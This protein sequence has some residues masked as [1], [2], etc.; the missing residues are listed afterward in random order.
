VN[1]IYCLEEWRGEQRISP[2]GDNFTHRDKIHHWGTTSSL[3]VKFAPRGEVKNEPQA[4]IPPIRSPCIVL[5]FLL[6]V[7][8]T[9]PICIMVSLYTNQISTYYKCR[10]LQFTNKLFYKI[11]PR[12]WSNLSLLRLP[13]IDFFG[14][15][16]LKFHI[17]GKINIK[18]IWIKTQFDKL[19]NLLKFLIYNWNVFSSSPLHWI[20]WN[21]LVI[22]WSR[23]SWASYISVGV[24]PSVKAWQNC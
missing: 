24:N 22:F 15:V 1:T 10:A 16:W 14:T 8:E 5:T 6:W 18:L 21:I 7:I 17:L 3:G 19:R 2:P 13:R 23:W 11:V 4:K 20:F 9:L 12:K